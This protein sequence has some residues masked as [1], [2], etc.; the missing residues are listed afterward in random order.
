M[1]PATKDARSR[2][3]TF[4][5]PAFSVKRFAAQ[6]QPAAFARAYTGNCIVE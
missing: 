6:S 3:I 4:S 5:L 1:Q 2:F